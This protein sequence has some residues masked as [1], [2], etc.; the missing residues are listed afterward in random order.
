[1]GTTAMVAPVI[2]KGVAATAVLIMEEVT[3]VIAA[4][5]TEMKIV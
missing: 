5:I 3:E 2:T 4:V 1:M